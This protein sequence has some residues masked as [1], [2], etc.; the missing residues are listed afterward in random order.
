MSDWYQKSENEV[1]E[2]FQITKDGHTSEMAAELLDQKE[3]TSSKPERRRVRFRCFYPS[4][5]TCLLSY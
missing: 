5:Q 2:N 3:K 4:L 1:L